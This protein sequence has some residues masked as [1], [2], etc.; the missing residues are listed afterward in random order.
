MGGKNMI[1]LPIVAGRFYE[2]EPESLVRQIDS[3]FHSARS[4][5]LPAKGRLVSLISPHAGYVFSGKPAAAGFLRLKAEKVLPERIIILGPKHTAYGPDLSVSAATEWETPLGNVK[6]DNEFCS[7]ICEIAPEFK[8]DNQAHRYE[9]SIEVQ[10]PFL[11]HIYKR[12]SF[13]IVPVAIGYCAYSYLQQQFKKIGELLQ[14]DSKDTLIIVS[15]DFSH[16][17]PR[18]LA[19]KLDLQAVEKI[20]SLAAQEFYELVIS[21]NRSICGVMPI[22]GLLT[23]LEN[24]KDVTG[25]LIH[26]S[27]SMDVMPHDRGVGY[28]S[29]CFEEGS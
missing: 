15:S 24:K 7:E 28:A 5:P 29:I 4:I 9:H 21:E 22:T 13:R 2:S 6:V 18:D 26:Y 25:S 10:L 17:T 1:R 3:F 8:L 19:Y 23:V 11:Q 16:D 20:T 27:T 14:N 12:K